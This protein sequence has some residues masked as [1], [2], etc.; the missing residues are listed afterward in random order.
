MADSIN[1]ELTVDVFKLL[2]VWRTIR[3]CCL[4]SGHIDISME[5]FGSNHGFLS[6]WTQEASNVRRLYSQ[7]S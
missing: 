1:R 2:S 6:R 3:K 5:C 7:A 4:N